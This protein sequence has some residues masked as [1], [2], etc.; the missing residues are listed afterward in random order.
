ML[1]RPV[2]SL[3]PSSFLLF[4]FQAEDGI[5]DS[6]VTGVQT[7]ALPISGGAAPS[8]MSAPNGAAVSGGLEAWIARSDDTAPLDTVDRPMGAAVAGRLA[9]QSAKTSGALAEL[10]AMETELLVA[11]G[12]ARLQRDPAW[13]D[14]LSDK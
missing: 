5:R 6:S 11:T 10:D 7:C 8:S 9:Q 13:L 4:F 1:R 12:K 2:R 14:V 3:A